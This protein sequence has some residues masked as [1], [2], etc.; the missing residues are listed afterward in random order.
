MTVG[1]A[2]AQ[3]QGTVKTSEG[4][5]VVGASVFWENT[6]QGTTTDEN[7]F[8]SLAKPSGK[9]LLVVSYVGFRNDTIA[10]GGENIRLDVVLDNQEM[11]EVEVVARKMGTMKMR[12]WIMSL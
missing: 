7:G 4:E 11:A 5:Q 12:Y 9:N 10:V 1:W 2:N 6:M 3:V 8:F